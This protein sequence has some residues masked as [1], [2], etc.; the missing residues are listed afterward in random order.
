MRA[1][2]RLRIINAVLV[3]LLIVAAGAAAVFAYR[4]LTLPRTTATIAAAIKSVPATLQA[5]LPSAPKSVVPTK[6]SSSAQTSPKASTTDATALNKPA[7]PDLTS[8]YK[9]TRQTEL[10][11]P[12][13]H[14]EENLPEQAHPTAPTFTR[15]LA[16]AAPVP[17]LVSAPSAAPAAAT[18]AAPSPADIHTPPP[19]TRP[20]APGNVLVAVPASVIM[21]Y[22]IV[23][24]KPLYPSFRHI[25]VDSAVNVLV[26]ISKDGKVVSARSTDGSLDVRAAAVQAVQSW[27]FKPYL[28]E[29]SPVAV[30][31]TF[32]FVFQGR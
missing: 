30:S 3:V 11:L 14:L 16:V 26:T 23:A 9:N 7:P 2:P 25:G 32:R 27:Q 24:P 28:L 13:V 18:A 15:A 4:Y 31:T 29:G 1:S 12:D 22:A 19:T 20:V 6:T 8:L 21:T 10:P 17:A 5:V